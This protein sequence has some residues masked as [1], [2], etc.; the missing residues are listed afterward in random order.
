MS[1]VSPMAKS[2]S[3]SA[4]PTIPARS[5]VRKETGLPLT[6]STSAQK[7]WP[8]SSGRN[9]K[10]LITARESEITARIPSAW[11]VSN[12]IDCRVTS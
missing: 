2:I 11:R 3:T 12:S 1:L 4:K 7:M 8:P 5:I 10:R 9:G 6:F